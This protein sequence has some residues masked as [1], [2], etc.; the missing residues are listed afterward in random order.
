MLLSLVFNDFADMKNSAEKFI[1]FQVPSW[2]LL[3]IHAGHT[4]VAGLASFRI[5]R[6]TRDPFWADKGKE[7]KERITT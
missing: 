4:F 7:Y 1:Q 2:V 6:E 3:S 5:Y